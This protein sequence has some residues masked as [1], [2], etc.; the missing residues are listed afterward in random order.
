MDNS[1]KI[2]S[3]KQNLFNEPSITQ[4]TVKVDKIDKTILKFELK[5]VAMF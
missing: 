1:T 2:D 5:R 3:S 4:V